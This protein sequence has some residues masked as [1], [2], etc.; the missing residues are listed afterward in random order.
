[1][2]WLIRLLLFP[3]TFLYGLIILVR[4]SLYRSQIITRTSFDI[5]IICVGNLSVGGTGKTPHIE[6]LIRSL[7][8]EFS[9]AVLSRGYKRK[10][11][12]YVLA[13][14][15]ST[16]SDIGDEPFQVKQKFSNIDVAVSENLA[17]VI[18]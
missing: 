11:V 2:I 17:W 13:N 1:M 9:I 10:T 14:N 12:G 4:D 6:W 8:A 7:Q 16:P 15:Q 5:P 18:L 3:F